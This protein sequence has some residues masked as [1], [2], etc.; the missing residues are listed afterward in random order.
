M[1][2]VLLIIICF[3]NAFFIQ[4]QNG[5]YNSKRQEYRAL[6][7]S[8]NRIIREKCR[9]TIQIFGVGGDDFVSAEIKSVNPSEYI[10]KKWIIKSEIQMAPDAK[11]K[12]IYNSY[13]ATLIGADEENNDYQ[14]TIVKRNKNSKISIAAID[15]NGA[16]HWYYDLEKIN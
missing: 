8:E 3:L 5:I 14:I 4:A 9:I 11:G 10:T 7:P 6:N 15:A 12:R 1:K 2:T 13:I 16:A